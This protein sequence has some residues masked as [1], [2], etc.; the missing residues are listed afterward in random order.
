MELSLPYTED[1]AVYQH[2]QFIVNKGDTV[3]RGQII[4]Y[5]SDKG[6][7]GQVHLHYEIRKDGLYAGPGGSGEI[8][9][10]LLKMPSIYL[11]NKY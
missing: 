10:P 7:A 3:K 5:M 6:T 11:D 8:V 9:N 1:T 4:G 2:A